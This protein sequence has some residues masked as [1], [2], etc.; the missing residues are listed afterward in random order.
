MSLFSAIGRLC[1]LSVTIGDMLKEEMEN[2]LRGRVH[3]R[4]GYKDDVDF[5]P[6]F[7]ERLQRSPQVDTV[8]L[9]L[10]SA[11]L[12]AANSWPDYCGHEINRAA[13]NRSLDFCTPEMVCKIFQA[14][15]QTPRE[16]DHFYVSCGDLI[17][18]FTDFGGGD[19][20]ILIGN[21]YC[22]IQ[23]GDHVLYVDSRKQERQ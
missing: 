16:R 8:K 10:V 20:L 1:P 15:L 12:G 19:R 2:V 13:R 5:L 4:G 11:D 6:S 22:D 23:F 9:A 17:C 7:F 14:W 3:M 18:F 21:D